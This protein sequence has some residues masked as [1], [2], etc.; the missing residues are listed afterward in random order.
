MAFHDEVPRDAIPAGSIQGLQK[1]SRY[2]KRRILL[3][4]D[5]AG[6]MH[7]LKIADASQMLMTGDDRNQVSVNFYD[8]VKSLD[9]HSIQR[10]L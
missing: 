4:L 8:A 3:L 10:D 7:L 2:L 1:L 5:Q 6:C 9:E